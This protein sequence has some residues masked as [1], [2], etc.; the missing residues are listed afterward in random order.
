ML[1]NPRETT[2]DP[3]IPQPRRS[4]FDLLSQSLR[5]ANA[6]GRHPEVNIFQSV[7]LNLLL[8]NR[9]AERVAIFLDIIERGSEE[10]IS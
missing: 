4:I 6:K 7:E 3:F 1:S 8:S 9:R 10:T 2:R 5:R